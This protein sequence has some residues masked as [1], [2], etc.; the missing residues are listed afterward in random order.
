M[1]A[2]LFDLRLSIRGL[3]RD[4]GFSVTAIATLA[5][6]LAL[7]VTVH[8]IRDA[9]V[10]RGLPLASDSKRLTYL[11]LRKPADPACCPGP[12]RYADFE[13]FRA[14]AVAFEDLAF[15]PVQQPVTFQADGRRSIRRSRVKRPTL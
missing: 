14:N 13:A 2:L 11:A 9:M 3:M 12:M 4:R 10:V 1:A 6:A 5:V 8:T 7:N 15:G